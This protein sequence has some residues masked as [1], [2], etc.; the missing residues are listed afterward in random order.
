VPYVVT[1]HAVV[2]A[3]VDEQGIQYADP[4]QPTLQ[5]ATYA[6]FETAFAEIDNRAVVV[7]P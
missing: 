7:R 4:I 2:L 6:A 1:E 3:G 5:S